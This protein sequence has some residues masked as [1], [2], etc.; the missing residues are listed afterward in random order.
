[1]ISPKNEN[2]VSLISSHPHD[3]ESQHN[4]FMKFSIIYVSVISGKTS[5]SDEVQ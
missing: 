2:S 4:S 3:D 5:T 1:M